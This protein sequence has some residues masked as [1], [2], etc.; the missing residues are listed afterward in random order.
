VLI[1]EPFAYSEGSLVTNSAHFWNT[2]SGK[3]GET[4][5]EQGQLRL[6]PGQTEDVVAAFPTGSVAKGSNVVLYAA[7]KLIVRSL[8]RNAPGLL[9]H[10]ASGS[11]LRGRVYAGTTNAGAGRFL[12]SVANGSTNFV[13]HAQD[14]LTNTI[15]T[16]VTRYNVDWAST[17][18]W[19]NPASEQDLCTEGM[20]AQTAV[21]ISA[22]GF[23]Q[24][25][26]IEGEWLIDDLRVGTDFATVLTRPRP[27]NLTLT[28]VVQGRNMVILWDEP[29]TQL[30]WSLAPMGPY[31]SVSGAARQFTAP[32]QGGSMFFRLKPISGASVI[33][34]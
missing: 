11:T 5:V 4:K 7:F 29:Q 28:Y 21:S 2:R 15:Y 17:A 1:D 22:Y 19:V 16:V 8:P 13:E 3:T 9:A 20:D 10:F 32:L 6:L 25:P 23:R 33:G 12:L 31:V 34:M 30:Q 24:D 26:D 14:L 18:L 27:V